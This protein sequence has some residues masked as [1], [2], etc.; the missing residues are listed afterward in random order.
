MSSSLKLRYGEPL[1]PDP[2]QPYGEVLHNILE[3]V[4]GGLQQQP[5]S[6]ELWRLLLLLFAFAGQQQLDN[7]AEVGI[8]RLLGVPYL[9]LLT[10]T[11]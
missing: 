5:L 1:P 2:E 8:Q 3:I 6:M 10:M 11:V 4:V 9:V 7:V